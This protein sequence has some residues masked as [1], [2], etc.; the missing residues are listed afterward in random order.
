VAAIAAH[1]LNGL[2]NALAPDVA[3]TVIVVVIRAVAPCNTLAALQRCHDFGLT[4]FVPYYRRSDSGLQSFGGCS[5]VGD[6]QT[7][8]VPI[9][10]LV[11]SCDD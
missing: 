5:F 8:D 1:Q 2:H 9:A 3:N 4:P 6:A 7:A 10:D 11:F